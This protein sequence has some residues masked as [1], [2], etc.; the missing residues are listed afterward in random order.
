MKYPFALPVLFAST[1][2]GLAFTPPITR[3]YTYGIPSGAPPHTT[4][5]PAC[6]TVDGYVLVAAPT[7][8]F[9]PGTTT[10]LVPPQ[11]SAKTRTF[12]NAEYN[13]TQ[14]LLIQPLEGPCVPKDFSI[15]TPS[16]AGAFNLS[17]YTATGVDLFA[18]PS[19]T[20]AAA[21]PLDH[22]ELEEQEKKGQRSVDAAVQPILEGLNR[23]TMILQDLDSLFP[24]ADEIGA[25]TTTLFRRQSA[26][27]E[28]VLQLLDALR[29]IGIIL[30]GLQPRLV[31][32]APFE[33]DDDADGKISGDAVVRA[34]G[35]HVRA[36]EGLLNTLVGRARVIR[37]VPAEDSVAVG[38]LAAAAAGGA[39]AVGSGEE[40]RLR[41][42]QGGDGRVAAA[43]AAVLRGL[44]GVVGQVVYDV[45]VLVPAR[46][47][48]VDGLHEAV[49]EAFG[50][51]VA[52]Y[53]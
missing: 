11:A 13:L 38:K 33:N 22:D 40:G 14:V 24:V 4:T 26:A 48:C 51:A 49:D 52:A 34:L 2:L 25:N 45:G 18:A 37:L 5:L 8:P 6:G 32:L 1:A 50:E 44:R 53:E 47:E 7:S 17:Q 42:R 3:T 19:S 15:L 10:I 28:P 43:L 20:A 27:L 41:K 23:A 21:C 12:T 36:Q 30:T 31:A 16:A 9:V 46:S 29:Q 39:M 35:A